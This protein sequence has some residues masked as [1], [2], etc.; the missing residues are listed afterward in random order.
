MDS[1]KA[2]KAPKLCF[3]GQDIRRAI[4]ARVAKELVKQIIDMTKDE[5]SAHEVIFDAYKG[6]HN[7][8]EGLVEAH[9]LD[10]DVLADCAI[11]AFDQEGV[12]T[13]AAGSNDMEG[14]SLMLE[15]PLWEPTPSE[16]RFIVSLMVLWITLVFLPSHLRFQLLVLA[17]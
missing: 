6:S 15:G 1:L 2:P 12:A 4:P 10:F 17:K 16:K 9:S 8:I 13:P 14:F 7:A 5:R 11:E 3:N